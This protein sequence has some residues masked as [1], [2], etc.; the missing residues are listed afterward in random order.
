MKHMRAVWLFG[1]TFWLLQVN[2]RAQPVWTDQS[3]GR[4]LSL[5][6]L[7]PVKDN[8]TFITSTVY[9]SVRWPLAEGLTLAAEVPF[10]HAGLS[11]KNPPFDSTANKF[12]N[13][14]LGLEFGSRA[15]PLFFETGVRAPLVGSEDFATFIGLISDADR[16]EAFVPDALSLLGLVNIQPLEPRDRAPLFLRLRF[17]P[18]LLVNLGDGE[19]TLLAEG[20]ETELYFLYSAQASARLNKLHL[21]AGFT[22]RLVVTESGDFA[23]RTFLQ[24]GLAARLNLRH[25]RPGVHVRIPLED[26]LKEVVDLIVGAHLSLALSPSP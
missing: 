3:A 12:G 9:L 21:E 22:G 25:L 2:L 6:T 4:V 1:L 20:N 14:Y 5:E 19:L 15:A 10:T 17:G 18:S 13:P 16:L 24:L 8:T 11:F 7:K 23:R 26:D